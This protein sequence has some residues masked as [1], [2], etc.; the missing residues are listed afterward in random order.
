[1]VS[2]LYDSI[3]QSRQAASAEGGANRASAGYKAHLS[4]HTVEHEL[5]SGTAFQVSLDT[6]D[7]ALLCS[8]IQQVQQ[9]RTSRRWQLQ[10]S[11]V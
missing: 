8:I 7:D 4:A 6:R 10:L 5:N 1:M 9:H 11:A 2:D 3:H